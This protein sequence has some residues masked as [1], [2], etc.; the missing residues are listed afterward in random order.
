MKRFLYATLAMLTVT[1]LHGCIQD[2]IVIHIKPDGSG[3]IEETTL[4]SNSMLEIMESF[5]GSIGSG[6]VQEKDTQNK[7][8]APTNQSAEEKKK[9]RDDL[10]AKMV[11]NAEIRAATF[12]KAVK[13]I[14]AIP[15]TTESGSGYTAVYA[16]QDISLVKVNQNPGDKVDGQ[17]TGKSE[18]PAKEEFLLFAFTKGTPSRLVVSFPSRKDAADDKSG[19]PNN[20]KTPENKSV[21]ESDDPPVEMMKNLFQDMKL[22]ISLQCEG[23]IVNTN[24]TY[25]DG[26]TVT[27]IEMDFGKIM[28][29]P[30][31][32]KQINAAKPQTIEE[33]KS[34]FTHVEGLKIETNNPVTIEFK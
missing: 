33:M 20:T 31:L 6:S 25:R 7:K 28:S 17:K 34:L 29:N 9:T 22:N 24:A 8:D 4:F 30:Q 12:G 2:T 14:S 11:K 21:K 1:F 26:R 16:F 10:L 19:T 23:N 15:V 32:L 3:T 27:L 13:F 5:S 18:S